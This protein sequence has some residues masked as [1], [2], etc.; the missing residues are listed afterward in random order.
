M[1]PAATHP[2]LVA[3]IA[4]GARR[5]ADKPVEISLSPAELGRLRMTLSLQDGGVTLHFTVE[6]EETMQLIRRHADALAQEFEALGYD[7]PGF[8]FEQR[9]RDD[10][11]AARHAAAAGET[12]PEPLAQ[13]DIAGSP[14]GRDR[15]DIRM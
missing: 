9:G 5:L 7:A 13:A 2:G 4:E 11:S 1:Q 8:S 10:R 3:Q 6:R 14:G 12:S 15:L